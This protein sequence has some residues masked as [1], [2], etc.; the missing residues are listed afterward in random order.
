MC[1]LK[2]MIM[3]IFFCSMTGA[4]AD[5]SQPNYKPADALHASW[6]FAGIVANENGDQYG[7]FFQVEKNIHD[8]H[9]MSALF[10]G[11]NKAVILQEEGRAS[12]DDVSSFDW[13]IGNTFLRFNAINDSWVFGMKT[14]DK[15]GFNFKVDMLKEQ[16]RLP[17]TQNLRPGMNFLISQTGQLNGHVQLEEGKEQF[18]AAKNAWFR[19]VWLANSDNRNTG[20]SGVLCYFTN[21]S[22]F[23]SVSLPNAHTLNASEAGWYDVKG[24]PSAIS[25][26]IQVT[27]SPADGPWHIRIGSPNLHLILSDYLEQNSAIAGFIMEEKNPGF[28]LLSQ[29]KFSETELAIKNQKIT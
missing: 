5:E 6:V 16:E 10:D 4:F 29:N 18:V 23:Y 21:G 26:F 28:C 24:I 22:G 1:H 13:R 17:V 12:I 3:L 2:K 11:Q 19:E 25:R 7:Y 14:K 20:F 15:K 27:Q 8:Y 9:V